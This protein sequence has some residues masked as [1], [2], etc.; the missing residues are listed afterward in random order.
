MGKVIVVFILY[1]FLSALLRLESKLIVA[2][3]RDASVI[4]GIFWVRTLRS[5]KWRQLLF[6]SVSFFIYAQGC[7]WQC[8]LA[9]SFKKLIRLMAYLYLYRI[10]S[11]ST[12]EKLKQIHLLVRQAFMHNAAWCIIEN[13]LQPFFIGCSW[14]CV[15]ECH[16]C[17]YLSYRW[18]RAVY[19]VSVHMK[20]LTA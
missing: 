19:S 8:E 5:T 7:Q 4:R 10:S 3:C 1:L 14:F 6:T 11:A 18:T 17:M 12:N 9:W 13:W 20:L 2:A 16:P 15:H